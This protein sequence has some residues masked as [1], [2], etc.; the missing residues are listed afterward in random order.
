MSEM[1]NEYKKDVLRSLPN[2]L[3]TY[4]KKYDLINRFLLNLMRKE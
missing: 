3:K 1:S 4:P 2:V